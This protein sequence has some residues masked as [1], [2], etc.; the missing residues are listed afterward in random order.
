M[1]EM[2]ILGKELK[3]AVDNQDWKKVGF[4][5]DM[6][7]T[8]ADAK[9]DKSRC[10]DDC[11]VYCNIRALTRDFYDLLNIIEDSEQG[12]TAHN[13][14]VEVVKINTQLILRYID[15]GEY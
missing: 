12:S 10:Y 8:L 15:Q 11:D 7:T 6:M 9:R 2:I 14:T 4:I 13:S 5:T 3:E 1:E